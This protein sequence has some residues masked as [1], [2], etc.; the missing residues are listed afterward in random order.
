VGGV[1]EGWEQEK[2]A[3]TLREMLKN[4]TDRASELQANT[5]RPA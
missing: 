3:A 4:A 5:V 2:L 1:G